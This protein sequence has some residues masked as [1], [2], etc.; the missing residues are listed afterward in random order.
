MRMRSDGP[1]GFA[2]NTANLAGNDLQ[3]LEAA[4]IS[5]STSVHPVLSV[6]TVVGS[7]GPVQ[8]SVEDWPDPMIKLRQPWD[9]K[10]IICEYK[11]GR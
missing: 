6:G 9:L 2:E 1:L 7:R 4:V 5:T 8:G 10:S 3:L 11:R